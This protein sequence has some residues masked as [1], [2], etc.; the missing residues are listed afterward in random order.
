MQ[1]GWKRLIWLTFFDSF[2]QFEI[3]WKTEAEAVFHIGKK[4]ASS[5]GNDPCG[6]HVMLNKQHCFAV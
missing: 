4:S 6:M 3:V 5:P 1:V 2:I